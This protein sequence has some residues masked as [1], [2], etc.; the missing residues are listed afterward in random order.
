M[1]QSASFVGAQRQTQRQS[2]SRPLESSLPCIMGY[3]KC[4]EFLSYHSGGCTAYVVTGSARSRRAEPWFGARQTGR[5]QGCILSRDPVE[6]FPDRLSRRPSNLQ[7]NE[8]LTV[9]MLWK[10]AP[11][12]SNKQ[13][14]RCMKPRWSGWSKRVEQS[15][16]DYEFKMSVTSR[17]ELW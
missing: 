5:R 13:R 7:Q 4:C 2:A 17:D 6:K 3:P 15:A 11:G 10:Y 12:I 14:H 1:V 16:S 8:K 9:T